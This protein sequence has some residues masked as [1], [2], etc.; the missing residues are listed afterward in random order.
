MNIY[1]NYNDY[2]ADCARQEIEPMS[3]SEWIK[4]QREEELR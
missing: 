3:P 2:I 1:T 4:Q